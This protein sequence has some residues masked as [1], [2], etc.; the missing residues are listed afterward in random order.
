MNDV[1]R[2]LKKALE[3]Y[4]TAQKILDAEGYMWTDR[5][6]NKKAH[7]AIA[8]QAKAFDQAFRLLPKSDQPPT[9]SIEDLL[10]AVKG[11]IANG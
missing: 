9:K 1:A 4:W 2:L 6:G 5:L 7:P 8:W 10:D 3:Q 11:E